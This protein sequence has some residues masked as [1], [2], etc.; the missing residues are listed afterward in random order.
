MVR[1]IGRLARVLAL[2]LG[3]HPTRC[4]A[5]K[6]CGRDQLEEHRHEKIEGTSPPSFRHDTRTD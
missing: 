1:N 5:P 4:G 3:A 2:D 6:A